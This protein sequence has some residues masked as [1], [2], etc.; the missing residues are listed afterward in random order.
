MATENP[1]P[2]FEQKF[3]ASG[4]DVGTL[5]GAAD[6]VC[7]SGARIYGVVL[8][9]DL[10]LKDR[11]T[12]LTQGWGKIRGFGVSGDSPYLIE[13]PRRSVDGKRVG[14]A[15]AFMWQDPSSELCYFLTCQP[16]EDFT[17]LFD[18]AHS[19][20]EPEVC[21][22]FLRTPQIEEAL[23][24][25]AKDDRKLTIRVRNYVA[26]K[27]METRTHGGQVDTTVQYTNEDYVTVF[28]KL[29][30]EGMWLTS[31][32]IDVSGSHFC[33]GRISRDS[34]FSCTEGFEYFFQHVVGT[35]AQTMLTFRHI[36]ENRS[37]VNSPDKASRPLKI[38]YKNGIF[39]DKKNN[40]R[41]IRV[42][43]NCP[44]AALSVFHPNPYLHASLIDYSDGSS[45]SILVSTSTGIL[46]TPERK[47]TAQSLGRL[48]EY[49][50]DN[51]EEG[52][53]VEFTPHDG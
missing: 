30:S 27:W 48:C 39:A 23:T 21:R 7:K 43:E 11:I 52:D 2:D 41:L 26:R 14:K 45:Y 36:F 42:L 32:G 37:R 10:Q 1:E 15:R 33:T 47:A 8:T 20:L 12:R 4:R 53:V 19:Y 5:L 17:Y 35:F 46:I 25:V 38:L 29:E 3:F 49:I 6:E 24:A 9:T 50:C 28:R 13:V 51:F 18:L 34:T 40:H 31:L 44:N 16:R 22:L